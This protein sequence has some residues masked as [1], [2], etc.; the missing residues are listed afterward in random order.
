MHRPS[1]G[2]ASAL[3]LGGVLAAWVAVGAQATPFLSIDDV[4][5]GM[6]GVGRSVFAG[7]TIEEFQVHI[8]G[9]IRNVVG[10]GRDLIL[11]RLEG[12]PLDSA[13]VIQGMSGSPVHINGRLV[14]AVSYALGSFPKEPLAGITP[15]GE[16][17]EAVGAAPAR[18]PG[19]LAIAWPATPEAVFGAFA[20]VAAR[21]RAPIGRASADLRVVG[22]TSLA[23]L[24]PV[25]RP[26]G[27]AMVLS[28]FD[29]S[30]DRQLRL[31][32]T[33]ESGQQSP[34]SPSRPTPDLPALRPGDAF[35]MAL[36]RGD[37][38]MGAT[39]TVT[40][41]DGARVYAFG[42]PF[43]NLGPTSFAMTRSRVYT[44]LPS[45]DS[46]MK[47]ATLGPVIGTVTQ[48]R[49]TAVGGLLGAG[50][51]ELEVNLT[52]ASARQPERRL[53]F[54]VLHDQTLTPLFAYVS[55][56]NSLITYERQ[57]GPMTLEAR[58][59]VSFGSNGQVELDDVF[60]GD[61]AASLAAAGLTASIG[62]AASN[63]FR[64]ALAERLDVTL[65]VTEAVEAVSI[66]RAWLD[67]TAPRP[68]ATH[69]VHVQLRRYRGDTETVSLPIDMPA[70]ASGPLTLLVCDASTLTALEQRELKPARPAS[71][72]ALLAQMNAARRNNRLYVRLLAASPGAVVGGE[73]LPALPASVRTVFDEDKTVASAP[74]ARTAVGA[75]ERRLPHAVRGSRELTITL[76]P[77]NAGSSSRTP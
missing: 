1:P 41:V 44:V 11:A 61:M 72:P 12:G 19:D 66:E 22:P 36:I 23:D 37:L 30:L 28:G 27:A 70:Q 43:L 8:L 50:P 3:A 39:G 6:V 67:T 47:I 75:W 48:D 63:E 49:A 74:V 5:P 51:R 10:P 42:H 59:S 34:V 18:A 45:L 57:A 13:G 15:I 31:A 77:R 7:D 53:R 64:P 14:G 52:L 76:R 26:I 58:G 2:A 68:G 71:W 38:E 25:L 46:S 4:R 21:A 16:M 29:A 73:T 9:V 55:V 62:A 20:R 60:A 40:H 33:D 69:T 56:L 17:L 65:R 54:F 24:A 35:G 32:L